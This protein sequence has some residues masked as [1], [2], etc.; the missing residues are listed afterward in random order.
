MSTI[1]RCARLRYSSTSHPLKPSSRQFHSTAPARAL[2]LSAPVQSY[3]S[4][5]RD[6]YLNLSIEHHLLSN[7]ALME[8]AKFYYISGF[9]LTV[10]PESILTVAAHACQTNKPFMMNLSAPFI[11]EFFGDRLASALPFI[12]ILFGNET[13]ASTWAKVNKLENTSDVI[14]IAKKMVDLP[15]SNSKRQRTVIFTQG[16]GPVVVAQAGGQVTTFPIINLPL[17]K[18]VDTN[19]AGDA[20]VGGFLAQ[21]IQAQP[22]EECVKCGIWAATVI[23]QQQGCTFPKDKFYPSS[24]D[25]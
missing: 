18:I 9:F 3:V 21:Y 10:S 17:E 16:E 5:S 22:L 1:S 8:G 24:N 6:P 23:I 15:K 12:D 4:R 11:S 19:G 14:E 25:N 7:S 20:F 2:D 13:E